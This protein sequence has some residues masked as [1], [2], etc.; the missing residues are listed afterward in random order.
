MDSPIRPLSCPE[1][2][3]ASSPDRQFPCSAKGCSSTLLDSIHSEHTSTLALELFDDEIDS[4]APCKRVS[5]LIDPSRYVGRDAIVPVT[6]SQVNAAPLGLPSV[7]YP[8]VEHKRVNWIRERKTKLRNKVKKLREVQRKNFKHAK[9]AFHLPPWVAR[10]KSKKEDSAISYMRKNIS[11]PLP[12]KVIDSSVE[13]YPPLGYHE[14]TTEGEASH[15]NIPC[16][17]ELGY[18]S[19]PN[20]PIKLDSWRLQKLRP[21]LPKHITPIWHKRDSANCLTSEEGLGLAIASPLSF[22]LPVSDTRTEPRKHGPVARHGM[23]NPRTATYAQRPQPRAEAE[24][25]KWATVAAIHYAENAQS[26]ITG[27][28]NI[29]IGTS[30]SKIKGLQL[31]TQSRGIVLAKSAQTILS[32]FIFARKDLLN[33][34]GVWA[35]VANVVLEE[36]DERS[37]ESRIDID[38][39]HIKK[40]L[41]LMDKAFNYYRICALEVELL[42][43]TCPVL[44]RFS[45]TGKEKT[46]EMVENIIPPFY[47]WEVFDYE[48]ERMEPKLPDVEI[49]KNEMD[50]AVARAAKLMG[51]RGDSWDGWG[52][53]LMRKDEKIRSGRVLSSAWENSSISDIG[54][55]MGGSFNAKSIRFEDLNNVIPLMS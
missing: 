22:P 37:F 53:D 29:D 21:K 15:I 51:M 36:P 25:P 41:L 46:E 35:P 47:S 39:T 23:K 12:T 45:L 9:R 24:V 52:Q 5:S 19:L 27:T 33:V 32:D 55:E 34:F 10:L 43:L 13:G 20:R 16:L 40:T 49:M 8:E 11:Q 4:I 31:T 48:L 2:H 1:I 14:E 54:G 7:Y 26:K 3:L 44:Q 6:T 28:E 50:L 18:P 17:V 30:C 42:R 38:R